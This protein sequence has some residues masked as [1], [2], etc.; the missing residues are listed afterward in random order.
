M[1]ALGR[2]IEVHE[3]GDIFNGTP[4]KGAFVINGNLGNQP[5]VGAIGGTYATAQVTLSGADRATV[6]P[7]HQECLKPN[8]CPNGE[9]NFLFRIL[10]YKHERQRL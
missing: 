3:P 1:D 4:A 6:T 9:W 8:N 2:L 5:D 7:G 10:R